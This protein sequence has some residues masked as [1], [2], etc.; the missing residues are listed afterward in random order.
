MGINKQNSIR[1]DLKVNSKGATQGLNNVEKSAK[2][3]SKGISILGRNFNLLQVGITAAVGAFALVIKKGSEFAKSLSSLKAVSG[4]TNKEMQM[5]SSQAKE[6]GASTAFT[7]SEVVSLQTEL[8]K[9]GNSA[10]DIE[11]STP[12]ILNLAASLEVGLADAASFAGST[13][14]S[15]GL[16]ASDTQRI[17]DVMAES[18]ASSAQDFYTLKESFTQAAPAASALGVSVEKTSALLGVLANSGITGGAAGT[19]LKNAFI[20]LK[21]EGLSLQDGLD[22]I[23]NSSDKLGTAIELAGKRGGPALLIL[24][25]NQKDIGLL[26]EKLNGAAGAAERMAEV[27]LDNLAGDV[28]KMQSAFEGFI[29]SLSG[30]TGIV[31]G[32]LRSVIQ[33]TSEILNFFTTVERG[34]DQT[35]K[36]MLEIGAFQSQMESLDD[37]IRDTTTN[38]E[39]LKI[40]QDERLGII[41]SLQK[42]YPKFLSNLDAEKVSTEDLNKALEGVNENLEQKIILQRKGEDIADQAEETADALEQ[43]LSGRRTDALFAAQILNDYK[44]KG[45]KLN[46]KTLQ[47]IGKEIQRRKEL[48]KQ[49][50]DERYWIDFIKDRAKDRERE[51]TIL[52][53]E[54]KKGNKLLK[55]RL[56]LEKTLGKNLKQVTAEGEVTPKK[57]SEVEEAKELIG[58][59]E[60]DEQ[61]ELRETREKKAKDK[62]AKA[63]EQR[64]KDIISFNQQLAKATEDADADTDAKKIE[65]ARQRHLTKL[66]N[67]KLEGDEE[68]AA[69]LLINQLYDDQEKD[70]KDKAD[71]KEK[72]KKKAKEE[73]DR[74]LQLEIDAIKLESILK[75]D[76]LKFAERE[77][78]QLE[79][80]DRKLANDLANEDLTAKEIA[81]IQAKASKAKK[82]VQKSEQDA[83]KALQD[84]LLDQALQGAAESFGIAQEVAVA[85]MLMAAPEAISGSFK[86]AAKAYAPPVSLA[87]GALGAAGTV[88]PIIKGLADI[89]KNR[90]SK[91]GKSSGSAP[92]GTINTAAITAAASTGVTPE[93][94]SSLSAN[95]AAR[96]GIDPSIGGAAGASAANNVLGGAQSGVTFSESAY[97][98][99]QTQ[100]RF[101]EELITVGG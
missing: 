4:A 15:F 9:L 70:R 45:I 68:T 92:S 76:E 71:E 84:K 85:K 94:I 40:A 13:V 7:A 78:L 35:Q 99:F 21:K 91:G 11:K 49:N 47:G 100:V 55:E 58:P 32:I 95:N 101:R 43:V 33:T 90:F 39:D 27:K 50:V 83:H 93:T 56:E 42:Q 96:L 98:D 24:S 89:K 77:R 26:D 3:S 65:L 88:A 59:G 54:R 80:L 28:T 66:E 41:Q 69:K 29:L 82:A 86:E 62:A 37:V 23:A 63:R 25:K 67:L 60:T 51:E 38:E 20:E 10:S 57:D 30:G 8:A 5:L 64:K 61:R 14:N 87:M 74:E 52:S 22:K 81:A 48:G 31:N 75:N 79:Y 53:K 17:V 1:T 44:E 18:A 36:A 6:L 73:R 2:K 97:Q 34:S 46:A 72:E 12:A 19:A 16:E